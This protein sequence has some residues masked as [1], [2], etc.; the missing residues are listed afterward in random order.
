V[1]PL[2]ASLPPMLAATGRFPARDAEH[3]AVEVKWDG[4]RALAFISHGQLVLR[5]RTGRDITEMYPELAGMH[6][7]G[8]SQAL[9][10]GEI[11]AMDDAGLPDFEALQSRI[12]VEDAS[13]AALRAR[14]IPVSYVAFDLLQLDGRRLTE[15]AY[16]ERRDLLAPLG[17]GC[18][19][20]VPAAFPGADFEAVLAATRAAGTEGVMSKRLASRYEPGTRSASWLK[21]K[22]A[23]RQ[24]V[25]IA[26]WTRGQGNR[27][28]LAGALLMGTYTADGAL[29]Y[30][31]R[32]GTGF[33]DQSIRAISRSLVPLHR[34]SSPFAA[35]LPAADIRGVTWVWP[36]LVAE[37]A[38]ERW[39][40][41]GRMRSPA[42]KGLRDDKDPR[43]VV[44][45]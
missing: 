21:A 20:S 14:L 11:V 4:A 35:P 19:I 38:F 45:E 26:G 15:L 30:C 22:N 27:D 40:R 42:F 10:D 29:A 34:N 37:V 33:T 36:R 44:R 32:V 9:L 8:H 2:P 25:V 12:H 18:G 16:R 23:Y 24:E 3:W 43:G 41:S 1:T 6:A 39:T 13:Q 28:G 31:G 17:H 5:S 7:G